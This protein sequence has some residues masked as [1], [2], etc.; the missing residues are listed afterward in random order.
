MTTIAADRHGMASDSMLSDEKAATS[1][2]VPKFWRINGW[3]VGGA[4]TYSDIVRVV[5][6]LKAHKTTP[7]QTLADVDIKLPKDASVDLL[8]LSP[9]GKLY[10]SEQAS[11]AMPIS[12]G[13]GAIGSGA[14]GALVAMHMGETPAAAVRLVKLVDPSTGGRIIKRKL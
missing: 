7:I 2:S 4:G 8:I 14:Q 10:M 12:D 1:T 6:E 11:D 9:G 13:F 5:A 3:L